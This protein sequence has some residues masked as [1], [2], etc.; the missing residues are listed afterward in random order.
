MKK[1]ERIFLSVLLMLCCTLTAMA[2]DIQVKGTVVDKTFGD[3]VIGATVQVVGTQ[4]GTITDM[5]GNFTVSAPKNAQLQFS[6]VGMKTITLPAAAQMNV[7]LEDDANVMEE[8]VVTGYQ[9]QRKADLTGAVGVMDMK[10]PKSEGSN[11]IVNS[12][13]GRMPGVNVVTDP[14]PGGGSSSIQIRGMSNFNGNNSPLYVIDGVATDANLNSINPSDIE[15]IQVLKDASSASIYGSRAANGVVIITTK[16]GKG[17]KMTV[18]VGYSASAQFVAKKHEMLNADEWGTVYYQAKVN[19]GQDPYNP[20]YTYDSN[21]RAYLN[22]YVEGHYGEP[23]YELHDTNWQD[24]IYRTAWTHNLNASVSNSSDKGSAMFSANYIT[25]DGIVKQTAYDRVNIR[26]N[27]TYNISQYVSVGENLMVSHSNSNTG[28]FG[29]DAGISGNTLRQSP[30]L[31]VYQSNGSFSVAKLAV[32]SDISNPME[33]LYNARDNK[34][35][36]WRIFG[37]AYIEVKPVKGLILKSNIGYDHQ[38]NE[39]DILTRTTY[40]NTTAAVDRRFGKGDT[41]TWTN[42]ANYTHTFDKHTITGLLGSEAISYKYSGFSAGRREYRVEDDHYMVLDAGTGERYNGGSKNGW[43]LFSIFGKVDYNYADRYL[44]SA[45]L[46]HDA[47]SRLGKNDNSGVFPA[48]SAAWRMTEESFWKKNDILSD[49]KLRLA[50]GQNGNS[51][52]GEYATYTTYGPTNSG[53]YDIT[54]SGTG[55]TPGLGVINKGTEGLKW[56]TTTQFNVGVDTRW[57]GG[58]IGFAADFYVKTTKDM[59]TQPPVISAMGENALQWRNTGNMR[60]VGIEATVD[61]RSPQYGDFSWDGSFNVS[62]YKNKVIK[63]ND[64]QKTIGG[65]IRLIEGKPMGQFYGYVCDGIFQ[66]AEQVANHATQQGAAPGRLIFRDLNGDGQVNED[67]RC[68]I[69]DP[70]SDFS[71]SLNLGLKYKGF[72]LAM[73]FTGDFGFDVWNQTKG[74]TDFFSYGNPTNNR[75]KG[76]LNAWTP[77]NPGASIPAV[78]MTDN[79]NE[80]RFSTYYVEDG[81]YFKMKYIKFG[82]DVPVNLCKKLSMSTI[83]LFAQVENIFTI[84]NYSGLDPELA[85]GGYGARVDNGPYP[86]SRTFTMGVNVS[87]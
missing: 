28:G 70:N 78:S 25:Q 3:P 29:G 81:S 46:R 9:V 38:Q 8:L 87:F 84:T 52:I 62:H 68:I 85:V 58:A 76:T 71:L 72:S 30:A 24:E 36:S 23:G 80:K 1:I 35:E 56:E 21:G 51:A 69:G 67:D 60:N 75:G 15:S 20:Y 64:Q 79:N 48:F 5:D 39:D 26:L 43:G 44:F 55:Y 54:G 14:A 74:L 66:N 22:Q 37:N 2:Q 11:N 27:S 33:D 53:S 34:Y 31:P 12:L 77:N 63:L 6:Y 7:V 32:D 47:T 18:N 82:Y 41:W 86:R 45:T 59:L 50:W 10:Q 65:D 17:G 16:S 42:T 61:Y 57:L 40:M 19:S 4:K 73:F 49:L 83:N 13:Q